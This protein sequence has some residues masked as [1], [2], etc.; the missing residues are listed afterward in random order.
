MTGFRRSPGFTLLELVLVIAL[1]AVFIAVALDKLSRYQELAEKTAMEQTVSAIGSALVLRFAAQVASGM[2]MDTTA[3]AEENPMD[4]LSRQPEA[5]IGAFYDPPYAE[6][7]KGS[8]YFD[9]K[10][11]ELA[12]RPRLTRFFI[13]GPDGRELIRFRAVARVVLDDKSLPGQK[14]LSELAVRPVTP[15]R[16]EPDFN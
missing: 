15:Y 14:V 11:S 9:R 7:P 8:W 3:I 1:V 12:Y 6:V 16:W 2:G 13:P 5:Y 4:W 10:T